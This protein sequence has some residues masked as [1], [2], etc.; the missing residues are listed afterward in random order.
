MASTVKSK[1]LRVT[2]TEDI[3]LNGVDYGSKTKV[4]FTGINEIYKNIQSVHTDTVTKLM[5]FPGAITAQQ[6]TDLQDVKYMRITN[7]SSTHD[8]KIIFQSIEGVDDAA[9][10]RLSPGASYILGNP[11]NWMLVEEDTSPSFGALLDL[12]TVWASYYYAIDPTTTDD[13]G[14]ENT[15]WHTGDIEFVVASG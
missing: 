7:L 15:G 1:T 11:Q 4:E 10:I 12:D 13:S 9:L 2:I 6:G 14:A 8:C 5:A 3:V